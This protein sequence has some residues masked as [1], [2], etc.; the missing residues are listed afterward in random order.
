MQT[1]QPKSSAELEAE[2]RQQRDNNKWPLASNDRAVRTLA[3]E[4]LMK[5][6]QRGTTSNNT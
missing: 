4:A 3:I 6:K 2:K 1:N 5:R